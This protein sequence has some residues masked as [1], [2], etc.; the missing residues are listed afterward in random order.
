MKPQTM[1]ISHMCC[2]Q[3]WLFFVWEKTHILLWCMWVCSFA[4]EFSNCESLTDQQGVIS[5]R[6]GLFFPFVFLVFFLWGI[7]RFLIIS[8]NPRISPPEKEEGLFKSELWCSPI[9]LQRSTQ[10]LQRS[11][12]RQ[13]HERLLLPVFSFSEVKPFCQPTL[14]ISSQTLVPTTHNKP[15][16]KCSQFSVHTQTHHINPLKM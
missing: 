7:M 10:T 15:Q 1:F 6:F 3:S 9:C 5:M 12:Q 8:T 13:E 11:T 16:P 2:D 4:S 14:S